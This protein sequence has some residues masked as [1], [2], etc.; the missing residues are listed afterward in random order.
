M[1]KYTVYLFVVCLIGCSN[2]SN[3]RESY[4]NKKNNLSFPGIPNTQSIITSTKS[5]K[6]TNVIIDENAI[7]KEPEFT[8][9]RTFV[10]PLVLLNIVSHMTRY[11]VGSNQFT[12]DLSGYI[13][14]RFHESLIHAGAINDEE[15]PALEIS[16]T[17]KRVKGYCDHE[18]LIS[19][20]T[21]GAL[22]HENLVSP[23]VGDVMFDIQ[24]KDGQKVFN[25]EVT[26]KF[27]LTYSM[28]LTESMKNSGRFPRIEGNV[29]RIAR[30]L[31]YAIYNAINDFISVYP[32]DKYY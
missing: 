30:S 31:E 11:R 12:F 7:P 20:S 19:I 25:R 9:E 14:Y 26:G 32:E 23:F 1:K 10:L 2:F 22:Y 16:V 24:I 27:V 28:I 21:G 4:L 13:K 18:K 3:V 15:N 29:S 17:V 5:F 8:K 6:I